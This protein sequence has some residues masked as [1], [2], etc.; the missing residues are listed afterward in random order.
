MFI[1][2]QGDAERRRAVGPGR[3]PRGKPV[4]VSL[5]AV[6]ARGTARTGCRTPVG[7][8]PAGLH[9]DRFSLLR[10][11]APVGGVWAGG[12]WVGL[13]LEVLEVLLRGLTGSK[14]L[15]S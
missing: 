15:V 6:Y 9:D 5:A 3:H 7:G 10:L 14:F 8:R 4:R 1:S 2:P 12:S 11:L 13:V